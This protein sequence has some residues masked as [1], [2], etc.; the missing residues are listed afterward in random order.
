MRRTLKAM[1]VRGA[2]GLWLGK[3]RRLLQA[4]HQICVRTGVDEAWVRVSL[5]QRVDLLLGVVK[6]VRGRLQH[7]AVDHVSDARVQTDLENMRG[8]TDS[9]KDN[10]KLN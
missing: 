10:E 7:V 1:C 8:R 9:I 5:H 2:G 3:G 6:R 4:L